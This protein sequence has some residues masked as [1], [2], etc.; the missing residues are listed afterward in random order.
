[1]KITTTAKRQLLTELTFVVKN[2][3]DTTNASEKL[4]YFS[5]LYGMAQRLMNLDFDSELCFL[6]QVL[7]L[8]YQM[9][10]TRVVALQSGQEKGIRIPENLFGSL[11]N[12]LQELGDTINKEE[13][14][15][16][17]LQKILNI[18]YITTGNGYYLYL[19]GQL[20]V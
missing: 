6:F 18:A 15:C 11:E 7:Q 13:N 10:N 12:Y 17:I 1:M 3:R 20:K 9:I 4:Y 8:S 2:M 16:P 19:K 14:T 5:A